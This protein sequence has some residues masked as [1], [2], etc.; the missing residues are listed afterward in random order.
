MVQGMIKF[1]FP[2]VKNVSCLFM[3]RSSCTSGKYAG[4]FSFQVDDDPENVKN[5]RLKLAALL[6]SEYVSGWCECKQVHRDEILIEPDPTAVLAAPQTLH[7]ADGLMTSR[8]NLALIIKTAD[9]QP[10][11]FSHVSG[12]FIM[13]LH[14]GWRGNR[15]GFIQKAVEKFCDQYHVEPQNILAC[16]G[17]SLGPMNAQFVNFASE[18]G[19][20]FLSWYSQVTKCMNLWQL[21]RF[22]LLNTG[23]LPENIYGIDIC[24][25]EN[26]EAWFS[27]RKEKQTGRQAALIWIKQ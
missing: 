14:I 17:P 23:L 15:I 20:D 7:A 13:A 12:K 8:P 9:C 19:D 11:L 26:S 6:K 22:Q 27:Y 2:D 1:K 3:G 24:T 10:L 25:Y 16:R 18:W 21:T 4:N 5:F